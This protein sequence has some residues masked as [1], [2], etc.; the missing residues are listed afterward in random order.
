MNHDPPGPGG[1]CQV[2]RKTFEF[3]DILSAVEPVCGGAVTS[4]RDFDRQFWD[5]YFVS[6]AS[7]AT[8]YLARLPSM[9]AHDPSFRIVETQHLARRYVAEQLRGR[10]VGLEQAEHL[11]QL[12]A[13]QPPPD[14]RASSAALEFAR[15]V[16]EYTAY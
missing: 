12:I 5:D 6:E 3:D 11:L 16:K 14:I 13:T 9:I 7:E 10:V 2:P 4:T 8:Q 1:V 15:F